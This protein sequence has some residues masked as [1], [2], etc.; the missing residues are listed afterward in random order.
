MDLHDYKEIMRLAIKDLY[1]FRQNV[2]EH[3]RPMV[4]ILLC[5]HCY[6]IF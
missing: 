1:E 2:P 3:L 4:V 6:T 5:A